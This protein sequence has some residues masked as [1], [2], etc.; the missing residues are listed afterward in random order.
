[1]CDLSDS[2][3]EQIQSSMTPTIEGD[4]RKEDED[5][6][7]RKVEEKDEEDEQSMKED[8]NDTDETESVIEVEEDDPFLVYA[9]ETSTQ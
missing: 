7:D 4:E 3:Y 8:S 5:A 9:T 6:R 2:F 1:M